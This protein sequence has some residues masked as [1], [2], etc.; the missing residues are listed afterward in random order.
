MVGVG[1]YWPRETAATLPSARRR[2][3]LRRPRGRRRAEYIVAAA[4]LQY[5]K[6]GE[7]K[8]LGVDHKLPSTQWGEDPKPMIPSYFPLIPFGTEP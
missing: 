5:V 8:L 2:K 1:T 3:A 6:L 4:R 7:R